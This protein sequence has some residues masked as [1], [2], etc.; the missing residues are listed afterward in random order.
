VAEAMMV[1]R[2]CSEWDSPRLWAR[3]LP[4]PKKWSP[5][6][7]ANSITPWLVYIDPTG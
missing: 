5:L 1:Y 3:A 4:Q 7:Q 2:S 6:L